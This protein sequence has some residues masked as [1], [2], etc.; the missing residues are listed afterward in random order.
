MATNLRPLAKNVLVRPT[1]PPEKSQGGIIVPNI[2]N[3]TIFRGTVL[4]VSPDVKSVKRG[5]DVVFQPHSGTVL[6]VDGE[7]LRMIDEENLLAVQL[8]YDPGR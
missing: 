3:S 8:P 7:E 6:T 5:E 2:M 1:K 4:E